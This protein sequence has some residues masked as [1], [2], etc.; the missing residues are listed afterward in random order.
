MKAWQQFILS[1]ML[2]GYG[3]L[4]CLYPPA[5]RKE[6]GQE[7]KL[8]FSATQNHS[9]RQGP[10]AL[11][12]V[13][14]RELTALP[15]NLVQAYLDDR[16]RSSA[17]ENRPGGGTPGW[18]FLVVWTVL[19]ILAMPLAYL[20][21]ISFLRLLILW[22]G[23]T[24]ERYGRSGPTEDVFGFLILFLF[25]GLFLGLLQA[26]L[27]RR[28]LAHTWRWALATSAGF[29]ALLLF[30]EAWNTIAYVAGI[31]LYYPNLYGLL[32]LLTVGG[33]S[34]GLQW[35]FFRRDIPGAGWLLVASVVSAPLIISAQPY[36]SPPIAF[37]AGPSFV[38]GLTLLL[39]L[40][41]R[42]DGDTLVGGAA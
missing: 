11:A 9:A 26:R 24:F 23:P 17:M 3:L 6:F 32:A 29:V 39:L 13:W 14:Y 18:L 2:E 36:P 40:R 28:Y 34:A 27:L 33:V 38:S 42:P 15:A 30:M 25:I 37:I 4:L 5:F 16:R 20:L 8:V 12:G 7:M 10:A 19:G 21:A 1:I 22:L 41:R 31:Q 35:V